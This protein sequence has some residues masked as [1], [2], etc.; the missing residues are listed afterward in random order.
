MDLTADLSDVQKIVIDRLLK[1]DNSQKV[2]ALW[3]GCSQSSV[4][5]NISSTIR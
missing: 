5:K 4:F 2:I 3:A 1:E